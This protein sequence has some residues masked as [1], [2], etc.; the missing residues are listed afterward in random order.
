M[1]SHKLLLTIFFACL[2][3][4][5]NVNS[6]N[7]SN[8]DSIKVLESVTINLE[9]AGSNPLKYKSKSTSDKLNS[10]QNSSKM[11][12]L[13]KGVS[14]FFSSLASKFNLNEREEMRTRDLFEWRRRR[15][16]SRY[17]ETDQ[18][19]EE[20][21]TELKVIKDSEK[22]KLRKKQT[23]SCT[24][25]QPELLSN[26]PKQDENEK[27]FDRFLAIHNHLL[28]TDQAKNG[29][30]IRYCS[31]PLSEKDR[32]ELYLQ[33]NHIGFFFNENYA[34]IS[35]NE[36]LEIDPARFLLQ[37]RI[38]IDF[39]TVKDLE[40][41]FGIISLG[42]LIQFDIFDSEIK[43]FFTNPIF[44][45][46]KMR[47]C[48]TVITNGNLDFNS[49]KEFYLRFQKLISA[50]SIDF[51]S[52]SVNYL[53]LFTSQQEAHSHQELFS[54]KDE[55]KWNTFTLDLTK[56]S[57]SLSQLKEECLENIPI[58]LGIIL[59]KECNLKILSKALISPR[60]IGIQFY[61]KESFYNYTKLIEIVKVRSFQILTF[62]CY[63]QGISQISLFM[64]Q[65]KNEFPC[66]NEVKHLGFPIFQH[67][68][69]SDSLQNIPSN[70][71]SLNLKILH[72][73]YEPI[74]GIKNISVKELK[75][76]F[77]TFCISFISECSSF[78][79][80]FRT[81]GSGPRNRELSKFSLHLFHPG[82]F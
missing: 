61:F 51:S 43:E 24:Q 27:V 72:Q 44:I 58:L 29:F 82:L 77:D 11:N 67:T 33:S 13:L 20:Q 70:L 9:S 59:S 73:N 40:S 16:H 22:D 68:P 17:S 60:V 56:G 35:S 39:K 80:F 21:F 23:L 1:K 7:E 2:L 31:I 14:N 15:A 25:E 46:S 32:V 26:Y 76:N 52:N 54:G 30:E 42:T 79:S 69:L 64:N 45:L 12:H 63:E 18:H 62:N 19:S 38:F 74:E 36:P 50:Y 8:P 71:K 75:I 66:W 10:T 6:T 48:A 37:H 53:N 81:T 65:I 41:Q 5:W 3:F 57:H 55:P 47:T 34:A 28:A 4:S 78:T 49:F